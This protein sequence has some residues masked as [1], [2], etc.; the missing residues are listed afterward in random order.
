VNLRLALLLV[1]TGVVAGC[2]NPPPVLEQIQAAGEL[3]VVTRNSPTTYYEG[4]EG[5]KGLEYDLVQLFAEQLKVKVRFV[6]ADSLADIFAMV[7]DGSAHIAAAGL[8]VLPSRKTRLK[9]GPSY[10]EITPQVVYRAG[11]R[12]PASVA[13]L[14]DSQLEVMAGSSHELALRKLQKDYPGLTWQAHLDLESEQ[15]LYLVRE[16]VIDYTIADSNEVALNRRY[17]P[18]LRVAFDL[19]EPQQLAWALAHSSDSSLYQEVSDF[20]EKIK[21][22]GTLEQLIERY[23]GYVES[24][25]LVDNRTFQR[26]V[27]QRLPAY[28]SYFL[29]AAEAT[30]IDW[31]LLAAIGYQES[32]WNPDAVSPTGVRGIMM[33]TLG[34]AKRLEVVDRSDPQESILGGARYLRIVQKKIPERIPEPDRLWFTLA[35]YNIGFGHLEDARILTQRQGAD[36]DKWADVKQRLPLLSQKKWYETTRHGYA[37]GREPVTYVDNVRSYYDLLTWRFPREPESPQPIYP[38]TVLPE[39]L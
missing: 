18:E 14:V 31:R 36:P 29:E 3:V 22:D 2:T 39:A 1:L 21:Q 5:I 9:F 25:N 16:Q 19:T 20:F 27:A 4:P 23:Y 35:G 34:T 12:R 6:L 13:D 24:L 8:T 26:H 33:L 30:G 10:Q 28:R 15:L 37:R 17:Y 38:L 7:T 11:S 32:H